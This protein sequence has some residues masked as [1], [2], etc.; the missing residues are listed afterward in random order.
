MFIN[1]INASFEQVQGIGNAITLLQTFKSIARR[2]SILRCMQNKEKH[3]HI[4]FVQYCS[5][6]REQFDS[7]R[8]NPPLR[9]YEPKHAGA[10]LWAQSLLDA[11]NEKWRQMKTLNSSHEIHDIDSRS[12]F[13]KIG[14]TLIAFRSQR[15]KDWKD[16][17][18]TTNAS[19]ILQRL[20][21]VR[22]N[23]LYS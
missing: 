22:K 20:D 13:E 23:L 17:L 12:S 19:D 2:E 3:I 1:I 6:L 11:V 16:S 10:A 5:A 8:R 14:S 15:Y 21:Q 4:L 9:K 7:C 18:S